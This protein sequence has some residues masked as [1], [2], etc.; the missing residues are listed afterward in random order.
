MNEKLMDHVMA[1]VEDILGFTGHHNLRDKFEYIDGKYLRPILMREPPLTKHSAIVETFT[2]LNLKDAVDRV[3]A[4]LPSDSLPLSPSLREW[5]VAPVLMASPT[6][7]ETKSQRRHPLSAN[8]TS[9]NGAGGAGQQQESS[10]PRVT[11]RYGG[12]DLAEEEMHEILENNMF[13]P[14]QFAVYKR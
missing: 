10:Y 2:K 4:P 8:S 5:T 13:A 14:R 11:D 6:E 1:G 7:E 12:G 9:N 3:V